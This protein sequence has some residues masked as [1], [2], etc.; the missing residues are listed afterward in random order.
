MLLVALLVVNTLLQ[1]KITAAGSVLDSVPFL[2]PLCHIT[3]LACWSLCCSLSPSLPYVFSSCAWKWWISSSL[4][5]G[6]SCNEAFVFVLWAGTVS[7]LNW[8]FSPRSVPLTFLLPTWFGLSPLSPAMLV[9]M[10]HIVCLN[11]QACF[12]NACKRSQAHVQVPSP[13]F[14]LCCS[15][16]HT[17]I[18]T[19]SRSIPQCEL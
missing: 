6:S 8:M 1:S 3:S 14:I 18:H 15:H 10:L 5:Q 11:M 2:P 4:Q 19:Y 7:K 17:Y 13:G 12:L 16:K 9:T